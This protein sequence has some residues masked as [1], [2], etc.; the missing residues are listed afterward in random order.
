MQR[1]NAKMQPSIASEEPLRV[2]ARFS[3]NVE[4]SSL[5]KTVIDKARA[6]LLYAVGVGMASVDAPGLTATVAALRREYGT[7]SDEATCL[8][9]GSRLAPGAAAFVNAVLFHSRIQD[10]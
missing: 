10:D 5:P 7:D 3:S 6:L 4:L 1:S 9:D 8:V 2:L